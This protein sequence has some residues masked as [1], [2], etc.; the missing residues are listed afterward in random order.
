MANRLVSVDDNFD[1]PKG[2]ADRQAARLGDTATAEGGVL[3]AAIG[4]QMATVL[5]AGREA[6][7]LAPVPGFLGNLNEQNGVS[8]IYSNVVTKGDVQY[9]AWWDTAGNPVIGRRNLINDEWT[10]FDLGALAGNPLAAPVEEDNHNTISIAV[11]PAGFIH[12]WANHHESPLRYVRSTAANSI[13]GWV[14]ATM[15]GQNEDQFTYPYPMIVRGKLVL[16]FR[17]GAAT[18]GDMFINHYDHAT[19]TWTQVGKFL[20]GTSLTPREAPYINQPVVTKDGVI[21]LFVVYRSSTLVGLNGNHDLGHIQSTD[22]GITWTAAGNST[23]LALPIMPANLPLV[24]K[25]TGVDRKI[26]NQ[27]GAASDNQGRP[28]TAAWLRNTSNFLLDLHHWYWDG[29]AWKEEV[30]VTGLRYGTTDT[31]MLARV[32]VVCSAEGRTYLLYRTQNIDPRPLWAIDATPGAIR[33]PFPILD[34][35]LGGYEPTFDPDAARDTNRL[36]M[37]V[38]PVMRYLSGMDGTT[39]SYASQWGAVLSIDLA[40]MPRV[41]SGEVAIPRTEAGS[42]G[43]AVAVRESGIVLARVV[44]SAESGQGTVSLVQSGTG[45]RGGITLT[46]APLAAIP[47]RVSTT[48]SPATDMSGFT[49]GGVLPVASTAGFAS[50]GALQVVTATSMQNPVG[51]ALVKYT[52]KT[53][54]AFTGCSSESARLAQG[55]NIVTQ[56]PL[57]ATPWQPVRPDLADLK[58]GVR[59][60]A[61]AEGVVCESL[62][63]ETAVLR[64]PRRVPAFTGAANVGMEGFGSLLGYWK[65]SDLTD[66]NATTVPDRSTSGRALKQAGSTPTPTVNLAGI[67]G[68]P[69]LSFTGTQAVATDAFSLGAGDWTAIMVVQDAG[70]ATA[71][72]VILSMDDGV[73]A[74]SWPGRVMQ[75]RYLAG[76]TSVSGIVFGRTTAHDVAVGGLTRGTPQVITLEKRG[77][78]AYLYVNGQEPRRLKTSM[79][80]PHDKTSRPLVVGARHFSDGSLTDFLS[81]FVGDI[82]IYGGRLGDHQRRAAESVLAA[83]YGISG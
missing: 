16:I 43:P 47:S 2:V 60:T 21:H 62:Q 13:T 26:I 71:N 48:V 27:S 58:N 81:G 3:A 67:N 32:S 78:F 42:S 77:Q 68:K 9:V 40:Q 37:L 23:P 34:A 63:V 33:E 79:P 53:A 1:F 14:A 50:S 57:I 73:S 55:G 17:S 75:V 80:N 29:A 49:G 28:H 25:M 35:D 11:D 38:T 52:G 36:H 41:A 20:G 22:R 65:V 7:T 8:F 31:S 12:V 46:S 5:P 74:T 18:S 56:S 44:A 66:A 83:A 24:K 10:T 4:Q 15:T 64:M 69:A 19:K 70:A 6:V 82:A 54:T 45:G 51:V 39:D 30:V 59:L 72:E 76:S 61:R